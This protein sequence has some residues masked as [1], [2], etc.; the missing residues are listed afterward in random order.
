M[1]EE[2]GVVG[3]TVGTRVKESEIERKRYSLFI[4]IQTVTQLSQ[5]KVTNDESPR[6]PKTMAA[7]KYIFIIFNS[8]Y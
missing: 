6:F 5:N 4:K 2:A 7:P 3:G 8:D 1:V